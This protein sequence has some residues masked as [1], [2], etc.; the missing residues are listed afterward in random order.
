MGGDF[1][2][3]EDENYFSVLDTDDESSISSFEVVELEDCEEESV[4]ECFQV[5]SD[6]KDSSISSFEEVMID[7][8]QLREFQPSDVAEAFEKVRMPRE[9]ENS[10]KSIETDSDAD[11]DIDSEISTL[12]KENATMS[13]EILFSVPTHFGK[14]V[15]TALVDSGCSKSLLDRDIVRDTGVHKVRKSCQK[16]VTKAGEFITRGK[17]ELEEFIL[18]QFTH[19]RKIKHDFHLF[20]R[21]KNDRYDM[22]LGRDLMQSLGL[23]ILNS[24]QK[25][26]WNGIEIDMVP[27]GHWSGGK[28][29]REFRA[30]QEHN[31]VK[32]IL[33]SKYEKADLHEVLAN[34]PHLTED[35]QQALLAVFLQHEDLFLRKVGTWKGKP[36]DIQLKDNVKPYHAKAYRVPQAYLQ[37][38][39]TEIDRLVSIGTLSPTVESEWASPTFCIPKK[40]D[41]IRI[42]S[43]FRILNTSIRRSPWPTPNIQEIFQEIGGFFYVTAIDLN[44]GYYAMALTERSKDLC[45]IILPWGKYRY[46]SLPMGVYIATDVFQQR[47]SEIM[48]SVPHVYVFIDDI[49]IVGKGTY[50]EHLQQV[51]KVLTILLNYGMQVNPLKSFWAQSEVNYL[52]YVISKEG[53][54]PQVKKVKAILDISHPTNKR[55]VRQFIGMV[56]Y[57]RDVWQGR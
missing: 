25:F 30:T 36:I 8:I 47:L 15:F 18:P 22:V 16:W 42:V 48:A 35:Q 33:E 56:N 23:D 12:A 29:V 21:H 49:L 31:E 28:N 3:F 19:N 50:E 40:D 37:T 26:K 51:D 39:K 53:I 7:G 9:D 38:F 44:M 55:Q 54:R 27:T 24:T 45:T 34:L 5:F 32:N 4:L 14:R 1:S 11:S 52:G 2:A 20:K 57:Y 43:D 6:D 41:R 13:A 46:N 17:A 10:V